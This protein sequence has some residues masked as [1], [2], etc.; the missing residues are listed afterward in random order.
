MLFGSISMTGK[1]CRLAR[2][3]FGRR[4]F[5]ESAYRGNIFPPPGND[6]ANRLTGET[7]HGG[8]KGE[9]FP[10]KLTAY[11]GNISHP[12]YRG[13]IFRVLL[14]AYRGNIPKCFPGR[15]VYRG[16]ILTKMTFPEKCFPGKQIAEFQNVS[17]VSW[18]I[19][20]GARMF[21]R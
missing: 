13:N 5:L 2:S 6:F 9:C 15:A 14:S 20:P 16:N 10:G 1:H 4:R 17:P 8:W 3:R 19:S 7:F 21:P 18:W 11:R 12:A